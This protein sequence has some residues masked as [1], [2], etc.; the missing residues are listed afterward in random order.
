MT[1][2]VTVG[3]KK[4]PADWAASVSPNASHTINGHR[5]KFKKTSI[6]YGTEKMNSKLGSL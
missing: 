6:F 3:Q 5:D 2:C 1:D 4:A